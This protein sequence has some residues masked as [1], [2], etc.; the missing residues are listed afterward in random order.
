MAVWTSALEPDSSNRAPALT[1]GEVL[2]TSGS[3]VYTNGDQRLDL[4][5]RGG[6]S[7]GLQ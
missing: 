2:R 7:N 6:E 4:P 5:L 3:H 1:A